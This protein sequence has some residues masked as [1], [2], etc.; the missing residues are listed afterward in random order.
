MNKSWRNWT[1]RHAEAVGQLTRARVELEVRAW[2][3][4]LDEADR[5]VIG[6]GDRIGV[7]GSAV[8]SAVERALRRA[9]RF[10]PGATCIHRAVAARRMLKRRGV[11]ARVVIGLRGGDELAGHAWVEIGEGDEAVALFSDDDTKYQRMLL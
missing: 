6:E 2:R 9:S 10:V 4:V 8:G 7:G 1:V 3:D 11:D 5:R